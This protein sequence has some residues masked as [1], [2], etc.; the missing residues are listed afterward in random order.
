MADSAELACTYAALILADEKIPVTADK[1]S[2]LVKAAGLTIPAYWPGMFA[3]VLGT[4]NI[5]D[6]LAAAGSGGGGGSAPT[7]QAAP[8]KSEEKVEEKKGG[9]KGGKKKEEPKEEEE[10][11]DM[12]FGLFD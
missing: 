3:R 7:Q 12:G 4:K 10:D 5:D 11:A 9:D 2:T 6:L 8:A 1:I